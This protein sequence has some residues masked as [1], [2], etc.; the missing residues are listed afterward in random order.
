M[1]KVWKYVSQKE[2]RFDGYFVVLC[3]LLIPSLYFVVAGCDWE[4]WSIIPA[5]YN[6]ILVD[7]DEMLYNI[8]LAYLG[9]YIFYL[10]VDYL[11]VKRH[12]KEETYDFLEDIQQYM[13]DMASAILMELDK[14]ESFYLKL[15]SI[16]KE[17]KKFHRRDKWSNVLKILY[18]N[19]RQIEGS[20]T[21]Y[22]SYVNRENSEL[23]K[24]Y[25]EE[26]IEKLQECRMHY[27]NCANNMNNLLGKVKLVWEKEK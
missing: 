18:Q 19:Y 24:K 14:P 21:V 26:H 15:Y 5:K 11:P 1:K 6:Y 10:F 16:P 3:I 2:R 4:V 17:P 8:G 22:R 20:Y 25:L 23:D 7:G 12:I 27:T 13:F 9:S